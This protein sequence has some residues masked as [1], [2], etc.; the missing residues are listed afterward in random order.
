MSFG[1]EVIRDLHKGG[2]RSVHAELPES[3]IVRAVQYMYIH[4]ATYGVLDDL[5]H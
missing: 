4:Y 5:L 3:S 2:I 1:L